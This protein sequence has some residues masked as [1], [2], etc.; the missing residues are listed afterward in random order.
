MRRPELRNITLL[1]PQS[2]HSP[3]LGKYHGKQLDPPLGLL[4]L[5]SVL[6]DMCD[7]TIIDCEA[8]HLTAEEVSD[9]I[10]ASEAQVV[11]ITLNF[12]TLLK[13]ARVIAKRIK[14][15]APDKII[16]WGG[17]LATFYADTLIQEEYVDLIVLKEGE[18]TIR[19]CCEKNFDFTAFSEIDGIMYKG[20]GDIKIHP[21]TR[22]IEDLDSLPFPAY[23]LLK[24]PTHYSMEICSSR[25]CLFNCVY[26]S[27]KRMWQKWRE[28]SVPNIMA[29]LEALIA[30]FD[31]DTFSF[32]DDNFVV[33][34]KRVN[35]FIRMMKEK[36]ISLKYGWG[37]SARIDMID[38]AFLE[39]LADAGC[40][41]IFFGIE[42]GSSVILEK[43]RRTYSIHEVREKIDQCIHVGILPTASFMIGLPWERR[44]DIEATLD[45]AETINTPKV[46][47]HPFTPMPGTL[48]YMNPEQF[49]L[50]IHPHDI[51][52]ESL[53]QGKVFYD[54]PYLSAQTL[55]DL[56]IE[57]RGIMTERLREMESYMEMMFK[58]DK[59]EDQC[60]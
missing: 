31:I 23:S 35:E 60:S 54:T 4:Y 21:F 42:S 36:K 55:R 14:A 53:D 3:V 43:L 30:E 41:R 5:A 33:D 39:T 51:E 12:S 1:A 7:I 34:R 56:T 22:Y 37:F 2:F 52:D 45:L 8:Q 6:K 20:E 19:A 59:G 32:A 25:G 57:G 44:E 13:N 40:N 47:I 28:R 46:Q 58:K 9:V 16:V 11:G 26:C 18:D 38:A 50:T 17:N 29:E 15:K 48:M 49:G 10:I 24:D 27:T